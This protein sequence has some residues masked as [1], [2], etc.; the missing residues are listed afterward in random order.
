MLIKTLQESAEAEAAA[1]I[2]SLQPALLHLAIVML[3]AQTYA[4]LQHLASSTGSSNRPKSS[5]GETA[6]AVAGSS[7]A[8]AAVG[9]SATSSSGGIGSASGSGSVYGA[10]STT[11][12]SSS[13]QNSSTSDREAA[14]KQGTRLQQDTQV[15]Q[16]SGMVQQLWQQLELLP[17]AL[18]PLAAAAASI[19]VDTHGVAACKSRLASTVCCIT[20]CLKAILSHQAFAQLR[21]AASSQKSCPN[22]TSSAASCSSCCR[23]LCSSCRCCC[24]C[25]HQCQMSP[26]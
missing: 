24:C 23:G 14:Y 3:L 2:H 7:S 4:L 18:P 22:S 19:L 9:Y 17:G 8:T 15:Q 13:L 20:T 21:Q 5:D 11:T 12:S 6:A 26:T 16:L 10:G 1:L 25:W